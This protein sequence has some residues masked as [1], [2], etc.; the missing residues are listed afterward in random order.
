MTKHILVTGGAGF[1]GGHLAERFLELGY[2]VT[3]LDNLDP[4]YDVARKQDTISTHRQVAEGTRADYAFI[5]GGIRDA[6]LVSD[7]VSDADYVY[8]HAATAGVRESVERPTEYHSVNVD[9]TLTLLEAAR[10]TT[11]D[12]FVL[13]SSSSVYGDA[14]SVPYE[15]TDPTAPI[16]PYGASKLAAERYTAAYHKSYGLPTVALRYFTVYGPRMRPDMAISNFITRCLDRQPPV[17]YGDGTQTR[18]FTFIDDIVTVNERLLSTDAADGE[19]LNVGSTDR[20]EI[21]TLAETV[22]D[23]VA[24]TM[25]IQYG[26][27]HAA[28]ND[29][30]H[31][32][33]A[34]AR[35]LLGYEPAYTVREGVEETV[36]WYKS[37]RAASTE[38]PT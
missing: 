13:A 16:S 23:A 35:R 21:Q 5:E 29:H 27:R 9:G 10:E 6:D 32:S 26:D 28:D 15:E 33:V 36:A 20:I 4:F 30:T 19:V 14:P 34:K 18:D 17:V 37:Q 11:L 31:A 7:L 24:P 12:R 3:V 8:H 38:V 1:I 22:R 2:D 25:D